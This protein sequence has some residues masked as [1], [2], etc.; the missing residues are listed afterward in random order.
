MV[1]HIRAVSRAQIKPA[2]LRRFD[3]EI[4]SC[5][6]VGQI[7]KD[8]VLVQ[9]GSA[10]A[11]GDAAVDLNHKIGK[12]TF[13]ELPGGGK[14]LQLHRAVRKGPDRKALIRRAYLCHT[15]DRAIVP[16]NDLD[17]PMLVR[18]EYL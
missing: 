4:D 17:L 6:A 1:L 13:A 7:I 18:K 2:A 10:N 14:E 9:L 3:N 8:G 12:I 5:V 16:A 11:P 15:A